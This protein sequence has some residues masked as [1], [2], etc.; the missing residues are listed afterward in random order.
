MS[1]NELPLLALG[2]VVS[3]GMGFLLWALYH[4][5]GEAHHNR[6]RGSR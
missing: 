4:L 1:L 2:L 6:T 5:A 3:V